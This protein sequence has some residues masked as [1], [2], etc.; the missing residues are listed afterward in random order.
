MLKTLTLTY[1]GRGLFATRQRLTLH[2]GQA[3]RAYIGPTPITTATRGAMKISP[4]LAKRL[5]SD[6]ELSVWHS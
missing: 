4:Q 2:R 3:I 6:P 5:L 1:K